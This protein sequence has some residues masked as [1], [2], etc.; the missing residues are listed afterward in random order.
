MVSNLPYYITTPIILKFINENIDVSKLVIMVQKEVAERFNA[1]PGDHEYNSLTVFLNY[2]YDIKK[3]I[4]VPRNVFV[5][6]PNV[7]SM[8]IELSKK[9]NKIYVKN[10]ELFFKLVRDS[11]KYKRKTLKNNLIGY[12]LEK[13]DKILKEN[14]LSLQVRAETLSLE[15]FIKI[16]NGMDI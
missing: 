3:L 1:K 5:P 13:I 10:E 11:F 12:D 14:G 7:D 15:M 6:V 16:A 2:Y 4:N 8:V 9:Q